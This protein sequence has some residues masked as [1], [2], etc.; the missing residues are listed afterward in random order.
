MKLSTRY[1]ATGAFHVMRGTVKE[2]VG[3]LCANRKLG[4][5]GKFEKV[6]GRAQGKIGKVQGVFG[7]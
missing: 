5:R 4:A 1:Q 3:R 6:M 2:F 7:L